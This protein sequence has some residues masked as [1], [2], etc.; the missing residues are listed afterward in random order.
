MT[1]K[2]YQTYVNEKAPKSPKLINGIKAF[3]VGGLICIIGQLIYNFFISLGLLS[4][5]FV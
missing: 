3:V 4:Y 1:K 5:N 2:E